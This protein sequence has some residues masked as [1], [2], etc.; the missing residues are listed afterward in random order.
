M[1]RA[2]AMLQAQSKFR[3]IISFQEIP[4]LVPTLRIAVDT[5]GA[6]A[7]CHVLPG[8]LRV[9]TESGT[10]PIIHE[11]LSRHQYSELPPRA[12]TPRPP[13]RAQVV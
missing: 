2:A 11:S 4:F 6:A 5:K 3:R 12:A 7:Q 9:P 10:S 13:G 8:R 1:R